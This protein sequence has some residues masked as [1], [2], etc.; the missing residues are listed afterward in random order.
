MM[1]LFYGKDTFDIVN[2][3]KFNMLEISYPFFFIFISN[4]ADSKMKP[5]S[6]Y[7]YAFSVGVG[8]LF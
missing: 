4:H 8:A 2:N 6:F 3:V 5:L 7:L 1:V